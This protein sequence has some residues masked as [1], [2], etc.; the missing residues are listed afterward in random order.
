LE[1]DG[2]AH[3]KFHFVDFELQPIYKNKQMKRYTREEEERRRGGEGVEGGGGGG[4]K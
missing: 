1:A 3:S 2:H 4:G